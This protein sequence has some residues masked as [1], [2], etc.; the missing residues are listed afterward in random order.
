MQHNK[1]AAV[2]KA[3]GAAHLKI[4]MAFLSDQA[5]SK[6]ASELPETNNFKTDLRKWR[7]MMT[8]WAPSA[9]CPEHVTFESA[10]HVLEQQVSRNLPSMTNDLMVLGSK[11]PQQ[12]LRYKAMASLMSTLQQYKQLYVWD[13]A[14]QT[15]GRK[16]GKPQK[17]PH[18]N[19]RADRLNEWWDVHVQT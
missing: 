4:A 11:K 14:A 15:V 3:R 9:A 10:Q 1:E 17:L 18:L 13:G 12:A 16:G 8:G 5:N 6:T 2:A 7:D 19:I